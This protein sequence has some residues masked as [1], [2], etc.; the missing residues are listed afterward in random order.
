MTPPVIAAA[1]RRH[2]LADVAVRTGIDVLRTHGSVTV[3]CPFPGHGHLDRHPSLRLHLDDG[4]FV[5]FGCGTTG[6]VVE[7]AAATE[8]V[9]WRHAIDILDARQPLTNAWGG[10]PS[11]P[12]DSQP[13]PG[14]GTPDP[15]HRAPPAP[16]RAE[17]PHRDRTSLP[18]VYAVLAAA[19]RYYTSPALRRRGAAYLDGRGIG[20]AVLEHHTGRP[21]V[22]HTPSRPDG[23]VAA[24]RSWGFTDD[25]LVDAG[26]ASRRGDRPL[27]DFY[28]HRVLI[29]IR[30]HQQRVCGIVGRNVG[31]DRYPKYLNPPRTAAYDKSTVLYQPLPAPTHPAGR[32][33]VVEGTLDTLA[34]AQ[35]AV[36]SG[37]ADRFCPV[38]QSGKQLSA[39]QLYAIVEM[40]ITP[41]VIAFDGDTAGRDAAEHLARRVRDRGLTADVVD[42]P[43]GHDPASWLA[44]REGRGLALL[45]GCTCVRT[46]GGER[47]C[48]EPA[49]NSASVVDLPFETYP[50]F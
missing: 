19:W 35:A 20:I 10:H 16:G 12:C 46:L 8:G 48:L 28:R 45:T 27:S 9:A 40:T 37:H 21:E 18:R 38:T 31:A 43:D 13:S 44:E 39:A 1:R 15:T 5:C 6:D 29:P 50:D 26:L 24:L 14:R 7:W 17:V 33:I 23:L 34:I 36:R 22:G 11:I 41:P 32:V 42:L 25:E 49:V 4:I 30:D 47:R 2:T 3:R